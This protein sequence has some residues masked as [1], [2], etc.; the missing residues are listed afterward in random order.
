MD[1]KHHHE[2]SVVTP[3]AKRQKL[4]ASNDEVKAGEPLI[5]DGQR[6]WTAVD[7]PPDIDFRRI[8]DNHMEDMKYLHDHEIPFKLRCA[9]MDFFD[10]I[11]SKT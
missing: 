2:Q 10:S 1:F 5:P 11:F 3:E 4:E 9:W 7:E 8:I 6:F